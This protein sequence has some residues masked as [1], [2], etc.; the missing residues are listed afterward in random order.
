MAY[1]NSSFQTIIDRFL[2]HYHGSHKQFLSDGEQKDIRYPD[3]GTTLNG[4]NYNAH[5]DAAW[6]TVW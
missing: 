1:I 3:K 2:F 6:W 5:F 4:S